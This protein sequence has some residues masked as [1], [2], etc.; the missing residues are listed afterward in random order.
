[1]SIFFKKIII[2]ID[3]YIF[4]CYLCRMEKVKLNSLR[5]MAKILGTLACVGGAM[6]MAMYKG[7]TLLNEQLRQ[8]LT[9]SSLLQSVKESWMI[10]CLFLMG[11]T[12]CWSFWLILQVLWLIFHCICSD[13]MLDFQFNHK[14]LFL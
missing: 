8:L 13:I 4:L 6:C 5:S 10:G 2:I 9:L 12:C 14:I 3:I 1:M 7:P 11:S